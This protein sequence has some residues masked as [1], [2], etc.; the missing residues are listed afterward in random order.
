[1]FFIFF[2]FD[3]KYIK[4]LS[5]LKFVS[6]IQSFSVYVVIILLSFAGVPPLLGFSGKFLIFIT[7]FNKS[8][9]LF[10]LFFGVVNIFLIYFYIQNF[11]FLASK[12]IY[13]KAVFSKNF[14]KNNSLNNSLMFFN[15]INISGI[16][17]I[18]DI[19]IFLNSISSNMFI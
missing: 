2:I 10:I 15:F 13:E 5:E 17:F 18:E 19:M 12:K 1:M 11:R 8:S 16:F 3:V 14:F 7:L 9:W 6:N 4:T